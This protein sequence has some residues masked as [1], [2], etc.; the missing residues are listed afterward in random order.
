MPKKTSAPEYYYVPIYADN[1]DLAWG[2]LEKQRKEK[3]KTVKLI[4]QGHFKKMTKI[5]SYSDRTRKHR[6]KKDVSNAT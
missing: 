3:W 6:K 1:A 2:L 5:L 4:E